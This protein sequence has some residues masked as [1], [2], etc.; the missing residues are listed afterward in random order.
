M[1]YTT[2]R[3]VRGRVRYLSFTTKAVP[4]KIFRKTSESSSDSTS[5]PY[6]SA[7][8]ALALV[9]GISLAGGNLYVHHET[10]GSLLAR[11]CT[12]AEPMRQPRNVMLHR[13]RSA[14]GRGL[15]D[16]YNVDWTTVLGGKICI[17]GPK[18]PSHCVTSRVGQLFLTNLRCSAMFSFGQN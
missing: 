13:M 17:C 18:I 9:G 4:T 6:A 5:M 11:N 15:N 7:A 8:I 14:A 12:S 16:K 2:K 3:L 1:V 10:S